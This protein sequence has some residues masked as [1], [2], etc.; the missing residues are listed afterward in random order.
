MAIPTYALGEPEKNPMFFEK[1]VYQGSNGK[2]YPLPFIDKVFDSKENCD[3]DAVQLENAFVRLV[4]LPEIGGRIFLAQDKTNKD[5]DFFYRQ[6]EIKPALVGLAGPWISGG[7]EFNWPQHHRPST[8]MP[9]DVHIEA[10]NNNVHINDATVHLSEHDPFNRMKGMHA[11]SLQEDSAVIELNARLYN[12]TPFTQT[13]LWWANIAVESHDNMQSFFPPDVHYVADHAV[14]AQST[15]PFAT[16]DYYGIDYASR[17]PKNDLRQYSHIPV[18]TSYMV[19]ETNFD[20]FGAYD[21]DAEGGFVHVANKH[22]APGKKQWTWGNEE[23]GWAWDRELTDRVGPTKRPAPYIELM[24][25]VYTDNQPD[26]SYLTPYETK[27]FSQYWWPYKKIGPVQNANKEAAIRLVRNADNTLDLGAASPRLLK[28]VQIILQ[29]NDQILLDLHI[30]LSPDTPWYLPN[31]ECTFSHFYQLKLSVGEYIAYQPVKLGGLEKN[32]EIAREPAMPKD[33]DSIEELNLVAEHLVQYRHPTRYP[34]IYWDEVLKR[35]SQDIRSNIAYGKHKLSNGEF[36]QAIEHLRVA[37]NRLTSLHPNPSTGE[38]HYFLGLALRFDGKLALAYKAFY[39]ATWNSAWR[40]AAFYELAC[41]DSRQQ[42]YEKALHHCEL[43]LTT[44]AQHNK[45]IVLRAIVLQTLDKTAD[46]NKS[47]QA[48][49]VADPLDHWARFVFGDKQGVLEKSRNDAQT[50]LDLCYDCIEAGFNN[51]AIELVTLHLSCNDQDTNKS[52]VPNPLSKSPM[53]LY[54]LAWLTNDMQI[55]SKART[56]TSDYFFPSRLQD[57]IV[58]EWAIAQSTD[59]NADT[60][61]TNISNEA[62]ALGNYYY[63]KKRYEDA[64][65]MWTMVNE[66]TKAYATSRRNL[67]IAYWNIRKDGKSARAYYL[68]SLSANARDARVVSEYDQL[69]EKLGDNKTSRLAFL[70]SNVDLVMTR[71]DCAVNYL[72]LLNDTGKHRQALDILRTR[73]FH[74]WEGGEGKVLAQYTQAM[75]LTG[76]DAL[77]QGKAD[78]ALTFFTDAMSP[79]ENLGEA[80]HLLQATSEVNYWQGKALQALGRID[81]ADEKFTACIADSTDFK[82]MAVTEYS[83]SSHFRGL[84][85]VELGRQDEATVLFTK[86]KNYQASR[87]AAP[88]PIDYFATSLPMMLAFESHPPELLE[89]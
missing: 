16:N 6:D 83:E 63:D 38:A 52:P 45:A 24:A 55:L 2:I 50:I 8:F 23:F 26:F 30:D 46:A 67:G 18:P 33:I 73:R 75:L 86:L 15:F 76:Q 72:T 35:D 1:R 43:S 39:K 61:Y 11:I 54:L 28:N 62:F 42:D 56:S 85:L 66:N 64:I 34:E 48:L 78:I 25:G 88:K 70:H 77:M 31:F 5:F 68:E 47:L 40:S 59:A 4:L 87:L 3:Y 9:T 60:V 17:Q 80:Y 41:L 51:I 14:R 21:F 20:F 32:R 69:C 82:D 49:L 58:L 13:F 65:A 74:P 57:Q 29:E 36:T 44:N 19:C 37:A 10:T 7:V 81:E 53:C 12:R 84:A 22:I 27:T 89:K 79:P 71:D